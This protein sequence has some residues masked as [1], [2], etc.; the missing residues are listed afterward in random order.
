MHSRNLQP[1]DSATL[2]IKF[3]VSSKG[4]GT[5][6]AKVSDFGLSKMAAT[7]ATTAMFSTAAGTPEYLAP[8]IFQ[9]KPYNLS[10]DVFSLG[11]MFLALVQHK[12]GEERLAPRIGNV[13]CLTWASFST[14]LTAL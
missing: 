7:A 8:E 4:G 11:L 9:C 14:I 1:H 3:I 5:I 2:F 10:V 13:I 12:D 6:V